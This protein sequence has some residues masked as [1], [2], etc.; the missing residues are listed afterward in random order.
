MSQVLIYSSML[1]PF[2]YRAKRLFDELGVA[3]EEIDVMC[4]PRRRAEMREKASGRNAVPQIFIND[5]H[6]GGSDDLYDLHAA[7]KLMPLLE[8][9]S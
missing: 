8:G 4:Q 2:C 6:V 1:C 3:Y 7:G 9:V 5:V